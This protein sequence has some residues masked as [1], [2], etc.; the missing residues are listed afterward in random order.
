MKNVYS[1]TA[2]QYT[3]IP[4]RLKFKYNIYF[5]KIFIPERHN[6]FDD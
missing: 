4:L 5:S 2:F 1:Y 3:W 6:L